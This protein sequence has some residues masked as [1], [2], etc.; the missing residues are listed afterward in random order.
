MCR[1]GEEGGGGGR[2]EGGRWA[3][4][5]FGEVMGDRDRTFCGM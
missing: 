4:G 1:A 5:G 3:R 2:F